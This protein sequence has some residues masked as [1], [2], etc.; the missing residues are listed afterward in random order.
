M[1]GLLDAI[2]SNDTGGG[3]FGGL[4]AS[5]Q[6]PTSA[7]DAAKKKKRD[8]AYDAA[9]A[10]NPYEGFA[11]PNAAPIYQAA[12]GA[13]DWSNGAP[14][15][16]GVQPEQY[17]GSTPFGLGGGALPLAAPPS[18]AAASG[19]F[20]AVPY[21]NVTARALR[22]KDVPEADIAAAI[23]NPEL[24]RQLVNQVLRS[25]SAGAAAA[26]DAVWSG[27]APAAPVV[28]PP[29]AG[30]PGA[31]SSDAPASGPFPAVPSQNVTARTLPLKGVPEADIAAAISN[32]ELMRQFVNQVLR[33]GSAGTPAAD[34][35]LWSGRVPVAPL[36]PQAGQPAG[37]PYWTRPLDDPRAASQPTTQDLVTH[38]LRMKGV[39]ESTI[40]AVIDKPELLQQLTN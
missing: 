27:R 33:P 40:A 17:G 31:P 24:M 1:A 18:A 7:P 13:D 10:Q 35:A 9:I 34:D 21:Q 25:G 28:P 38:L 15:L 11:D 19:P 6:Y 20:P 14:A 2:L 32:P 8:A 29:Q 23:S 37:L 5:W 3:L 16:M 39:P 12:P 4:P 22:M 30:Q 26:D 36:P